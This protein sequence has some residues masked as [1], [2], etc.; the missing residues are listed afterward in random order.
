MT[1]DDRAQFAEARRHGLQARHKAKLEHFGDV[2]AE[3][4]PCQLLNAEGETC[5]KP[6]MAGIPPGVCQWHASQ[7]TRAVL[8]LGGIRIETRTA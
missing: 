2:I 1:A 4:V 5:G 7:I 3:A 6:G 8:K